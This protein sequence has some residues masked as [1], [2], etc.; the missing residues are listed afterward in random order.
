MRRRRT[1]GR[2]RVD[3]RD[4][5]TAVTITLPTKQFDALATQAIRRSESV[6]AVIRRAL[7]KN[8]KTRQ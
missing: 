3:P 5:S 6:G 7:R 2:P 4:S 8:L 1:P